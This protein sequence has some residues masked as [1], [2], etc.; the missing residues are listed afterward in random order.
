VETQIKNLIEILDKKDDYL[1][2][3]MLKQKLYNTRQDILSKV[4]VT[5]KEKE[6]AIKGMIRTLRTFFD[7]EYKNIPRYR[8]LEKIIDRS[9][10]DY[11]KFK[12]LKEYK[13]TY[14]YSFRENERCF[15]CKKRSDI[16]HDE[17]DKYR[18]N[19]YDLDFFNFDDYD[20]LV[21]LKA[22]VNKI[23]KKLIDRKQKLRNYDAS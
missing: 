17:I 23:N 14:Y 13:G 8:K 16:F 15:R 22:I 2:I 19:Q 18:K 7:D 10:C 9:D 11:C 4:S 20:E 12:E 21:K 1:L 5:D 6:N 3:E